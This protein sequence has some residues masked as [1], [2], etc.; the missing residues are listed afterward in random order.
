MESRYI[1]ESFG[2][3]LLEDCLYIEA[4]GKA[5]AFNSDNLET[6]VSLIVYP[7]WVWTDILHVESEIWIGEGSSPKY[8]IGETVEDVGEGEDIPPSWYFKAPNAS[9]VPINFLE[10]YPDDTE[11]V[12]RYNWDFTD[13]TVTGLEAVAVFG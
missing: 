5:I 4:A 3:S 13:A 9:G 10:Y 1:D 8:V 7:S 6:D 12:A 2:G 11:T